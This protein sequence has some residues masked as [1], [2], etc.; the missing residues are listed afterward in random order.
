[1]KRTQAAFAFLLL[2]ACSALAADYTNINSAYI[3]I[4]A[5]EV[6][7]EPV[8]PG[9][10]VTVKVRLHNYGGETAESVNVKL[11]A[12]YPFY[13]KAESQDF[14]EYNDICSGCSKDNAYYLTID[15]GAVS[16]TYP[17]EFEIYERNGS[18]KKTQ[19]INI[20]VVG[21]PDV[22]FESEP[23]E[24][25]VRPEDEFTA[26]LTFKNIGTVTARN[27]KIVP[28]S[29]DF[30]I[31]GSGLE[32]IDEMAPK[33]VNH[34]NISFTVAES[35]E[36][37]TYNLPLSISY[38]DERSNKYALAEN[39]GIKFVH[40]AELGIQNLKIDPADIKVGDAVEVQ[41]RI[42]NIGNGNAENAK[43]ILGSGLEGNKI[44]YLG[45]IERDDDE[46]AIFILKAVEAGK[47]SNS[48]LLTYKDDFGTH[49]ITEEF[50]VNV[51]EN[52]NS[53]SLTAAI[54]LAAF[55]AA[56]YF[57]IVKRKKK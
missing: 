12:Q 50:S 20:K 46:P 39:F 36:P 15:G 53:T 10:D 5:Q 25:Q 21:I 18:V 48:I 26:Q 32:I 27:I 33:Q 43:I 55:C 49:A 3:R 19:E 2:L 24:K 4:V 22:V 35:V 44:A 17:L 54:L 30:I 14:E 57:F 16:G 40:A 1:M 47:I 56:V 41:L 9:Q 37:D 34:V 13:L 42:E 51:R 38:V 8:E 23:I 28:L 11:N 29:N 6:A 7:P 52:G 31:L 45:R